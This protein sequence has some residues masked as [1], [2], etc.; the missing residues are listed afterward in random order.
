MNKKTLIPIVGLLLIV[1][2]AGF[3]FLQQKNGTSSVPVSPEMKKA[4]QEIMA[5][6]K[7]DIDFCR[8]T[9]NA[10]SAM[11]SGYAMTSES[12]YNGK[13]TKMT[14]KTDGKNNSSS[15]TFADGK[16]EGSF[17]SLDKTTY[18]KNPGET[19]W[20]EFP[21]TK[22]EPAGTS[23][24]NTFDFES[25][26]NQVNN[27]VKDDINTLVVKKVGS[28]KCGNY[29]CSIF[30]MTEKSMDST[31]KIWVD[32][33]QFFARKMESTSKA[34]GLVTMTF[35]YVPVTITKPSPVKLMPAF[36]SS[37]LQNSGANISADEIKNL[38]KNL[39]QGTGE[40]AATSVEETPAE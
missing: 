18:M 1:G 25:L 37:A 7:Y 9:A 5:N 38:M 34:A 15:T 26:K 14:L 24:P 12:T 4:Q 28:E 20:T 21:P 30:E 2:A 22:D 8:Y 39:P 31:T 36:D 10:A 29:T 17:I 3:M 23:T 32:T 27:A 40:G 35:D 13:K 11:T 6:C 33:T 16:E 19:V